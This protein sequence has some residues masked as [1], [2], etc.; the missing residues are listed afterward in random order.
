[1]RLRLF[2]NGDTKGRNTHMSIFYVIMRGEHDQQLQWPYNFKATFSLIDQSTIT[3]TLHHISRDLWP[4]LLKSKCFKCPDK[5]M[6]DG[7]GFPK[8]ISLDLIEK[9]PN[10]YINN[11]RMYIKFSIDVLAKKPSK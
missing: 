7:F 9:N 6:N 1:M 3:D 4:N 10:Q 8:F 2:I 5:D 11:D